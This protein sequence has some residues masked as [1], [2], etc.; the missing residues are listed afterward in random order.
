MDC[1][2]PLNTSFRSSRFKSPGCTSTSSIS[3]RFTSENSLIA[4]PAAVT[5]NDTRLLLP[6]IC[7]TSPRTSSSCNPLLPTRIS[8]SEHDISEIIN[9]TNKKYVEKEDTL[10]TIP[11]NNF[12]AIRI[13]NMNWDCQ[14]ITCSAR[15]MQVNLSTIRY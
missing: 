6:S 13:D 2:R 15:I 1:R 5:R 8:F 4:E 9:A 12:L 14:L 3:W 7:K 11:E 10:I